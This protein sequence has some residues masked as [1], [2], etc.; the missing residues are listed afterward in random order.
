[1]EETT[2]GEIE[3]KVQKKKEEIK[4]KEKITEGVSSDTG[5]MAAKDEESSVRHIIGD[6]KVEVSEVIGDKEDEFESMVEADEDFKE[7]DE[8]VPVEEK[9]EEPAEEKKSSTFD[10]FEQITDSQDKKEE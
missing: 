5:F 6:Q 1:M 10:P 4:K 3:E 8:V 7:H 2:I 9:K